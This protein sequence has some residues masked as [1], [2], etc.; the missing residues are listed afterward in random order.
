M[1]PQQKGDDHDD[2]DEEADAHPNPGHDHER[3]SR[4]DLAGLTLATA[5]T[6][7]KRRIT[8]AMS[9][10]RHPA[11]VYNNTVLELK[12]AACCHS[13]RPLFIPVLATIARRRSRRPDCRRRPGYLERRP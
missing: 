3:T 2:H 5:T 12:G 8:M 4:A 6:R 9:S 7:R 10:F 11:A 13:R 1:A